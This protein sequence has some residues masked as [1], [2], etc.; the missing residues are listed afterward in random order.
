MSCPVFSSLQFV[1][2]VYLPL[3]AISFI[4]SAEERMFENVAVD[5]MSNMLIRWRKKK[6]KKLEICGGC[7]NKIIRRLEKQVC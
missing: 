4:V 6:K 1:L 3:G 5:H 2:C 7:Y